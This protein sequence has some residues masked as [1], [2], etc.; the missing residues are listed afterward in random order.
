MYFQNNPPTGGGDWKN[1]PYATYQYGLQ[2]ETGANGWF[3][4]M[5]PSDQ[6]VYIFEKDSHA[7]DDSDQEARLRYRLDRNGNQISYTY[8]CWSCSPNTTTISDGLGREITLSVANGG[9]L[10]TVSDGARGYTLGYNGDDQLITI[11]DPIGNYTSYEYTNTLQDNV[12]RQVRPE[13]NSPY[14]QTYDEVNPPYRRAASQT[15]AYGNATT[16]SLDSSN[17]DPATIKVI[18]HR[19]DGSE[20]AYV[21]PTLG[22]SPLSWQDAQ[23]NT[24]NF[25]VNGNDRMI[26]ITDRLGDTTSMTYHGP[27]GFLASFTNAEGNTLSHSY[28]A[29]DQTFTNPAN[30]HTFTFT[31]Y[32]RT[33]TDYPDGTYETYGYD[34]KGNPTTHT[35]RNGKTW[36]TTYN[37]QGLPLTITN[38]A[39]GVITHTY[40]A[41]G[42]LATSTDSDT[43]ITTYGYDTFKRL[44]SINP[45]GTGQI[46][47]AY[48]LM[49]RITSVSDENSHI[50]QYQYDTNGNLV[51]VTDP[52]GNDV[53]YDY[54]LMDRVARI[55]SR[56]GGISTMSYNYRGQVTG[57]ANANNIQTTYGYNSR[58]WLESATR[59]GKT[60]GFT[61]DK[62][63]V[64]TGST[65]PA[66]HT[67]LQQT[68]KLGHLTAITLPG[69][70]TT[71]ISR[72]AMTR[73]TGSTDPLDH[74]T[75]YAY[76]PNGLLSR[77]TLP[78]GASATYTRDTLGNLIVINDLNGNDWR[79]G[80]TAMGRPASASDPLSHTSSYSLDDSGRVAAV[81]HPDGVTETRGFDNAGNLTRRL[82]S[83]GTDLTYTYDAMDNLTASNDLAL[84][85]DDDGRIT[86][87]TYNGQTFG[88]SF[89]A[90]GRV[91]TATYQGAFTVTYSYNADDRL[92]RVGDD[93]GNQVD[94]TYDADGNITGLTRSNGIN[95][96]FT[97]DSNGRITRLVDGSLIDLN[98][99]YDAA[100]RITSMSGTWPLDPA[101]LLSDTN[102]SFTVDAAS[103]INSSGYAYDVRGRATQLPGH[104]LTWDG[105][106]R[107][108]GLDGITF[109][110]NGRSEIVAR[111]EGGVTTSYYHNHTLGL[112]PI[113]AEQQGAGFY[114]YYV[115]T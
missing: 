37:S 73:V 109:A 98:Y 51:T 22:A 36:T 32:D 91:V 68:D 72:D 23:G 75:Q 15:D 70:E 5:D 102:K 81:T 71:Q 110:Y 50:V 111:T 17:P 90:G 24:A 3:Y 6:T 52:A 95:A 69:G 39:G 78:H 94:F 54:D 96:T 114:R 53:Q 35:D 84:T 99:G 18:E 38:P 12:A 43:G 58:D 77:V 34:A 49:D 60:R 8:S 88:G 33:R 41:D 27:T 83:D 97:R 40:N 87:S 105:A 92:S 59:N 10:T 62:E 86:G 89:D 44:T 4:L 61:Q 100:G 29:R 20:V 45:P 31:F 9:N 30:A 28:T 42:T 64:L 93:L 80:Y 26:G 67:V 56:T 76:D 2:E 48:D 14:S 7:D 107:L 113:V 74:Q 1:G 115:Y 19:P 66:G 55:T 85:R 46:D 106:E 112:N 16:I 82:Y 104:T 57:A 79:F 47:I 65:S 21:H 11:A 108:T 101:G 13:G 25:T 63:G 103:Q